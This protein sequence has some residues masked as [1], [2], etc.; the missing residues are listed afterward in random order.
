MTMNITERLLACLLLA[1]AHSAWSCPAHHD[2]PPDP[3]PRILIDQTAGTQGGILANL[4]V[5]YAP[6]CSKDDALKH[7]R[8][9]SIA[10]RGSDIQILLSDPRGELIS[11][12]G[13]NNPESVTDRRLENDPES[14]HHPAIDVDGLRRAAER[15]GQ[16]LPG[17]SGTLSWEQFLANVRDA[18]PMY[19]IVRVL[20]P[21]GEEEPPAP[22]PR[23]RSRSHPEGERCEAGIAA[24]HLPPRARIEVYGSLVFDFI[25][26]RSGQPLPAGH[27]A[28]LKIDVPLLVNPAPSRPDG[29]VRHLDQLVRL[30]APGLCSPAPCSQVL[31][32]NPP[33]PL[34]AEARR[35]HWETR[36]GRPL[37]PATFQR[38]PAAVRAHLLMPSGYVDGWL[39]AFQA[40]SL[41][42]A[43]WRELGFD[44]P[45]ADGPFQ[46]RD[47]LSEDFQDLPAL[48]YSGG[49]L[50][51]HHHLNL[52]GLVY[53]EH[54]LELKQKGQEQQREHHP[55]G[56]CCG[57]GHHQE[58]RR[59][60]WQY[61]SGAILIKGAFYLEALR[62]GGITLL[63]NDP[64]SYSRI[65][66]AGGQTQVA[67]FRPIGRRQAQ[68]N[69]P[70]SSVPNPRIPPLLPGNPGNGATPV[71]G[72][73][74]WVE[75]RPLG[76]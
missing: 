12:V 26:C 37:D 11:A 55:H 61:L 30:F 23:P 44:T 52:S 20:V 67:G 3:P 36:H 56:T 40:L 54:P 41:D 65:R 39:N 21:W 60:A 47:I 63:V 51:I 27:R 74:Q 31:P 57:E 2:R 32:F 72:P 28:R 58:R 62:P 75:I 59:P 5:A 9:N 68:E 13:L 71:P 70:E 42:Q 69:G 48:V 38:L 4:P 34:I 49:F 66:L 35:R 46:A 29:A 16:R 73:R 8:C 18:R 50:D 6:D 76:R 22:T 45:A 33:A 7:G 43:A 19:G 25:D 10:I 24:E 17:R 1:F 14:S 15:L 64:T 53:A